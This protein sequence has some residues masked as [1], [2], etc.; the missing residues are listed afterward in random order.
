MPLPP[1]SVDCALVAVE[2]SDPRT[3]GLTVP[4]LL[5]ILRPKDAGTVLPAVGCQAVMTPSYEALSEVTLEA[6]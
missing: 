6:G 1:P 3:N 4:S 5:K 2:T